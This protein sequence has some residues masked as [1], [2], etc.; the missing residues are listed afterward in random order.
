MFW[1][2]VSKLRPAVF[3]WSISYFRIKIWPT[4]S[5]SH[6]CESGQIPDVLMR[7][8]MEFETVLSEDVIQI[9]A[10]EV[11]GQMDA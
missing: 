3:I 9:S 5:K 1:L 8:I 6:F 7:L 4:E 10:E 2:G 11:S